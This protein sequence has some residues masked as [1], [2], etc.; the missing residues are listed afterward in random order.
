MRRWVVVW[1]GCAALSWMATVFFGYTIMRFGS[2]DGSSQIEANVSGGD[3]ITAEDLEAVTTVA[4][5]D[6]SE[7]QS[8]SE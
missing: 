4:P 5:A 2:S 1:V 7:S 3:A 6:G 8:T